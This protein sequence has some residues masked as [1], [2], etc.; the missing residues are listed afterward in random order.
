MTP[1]KAR[2]I[3]KHFYKPPRH[4]GRPV[5][6]P[7]KTMNRPRVLY[8]NEINIGNLTPNQINAMLESMG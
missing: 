5:Y 6:S 7:P 8:M 4:P 2:Q 1:N 3:Q